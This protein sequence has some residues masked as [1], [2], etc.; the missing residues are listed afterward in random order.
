[1]KE[2]H[3]YPSPHF[4]WP[5]R[6]PLSTPLQNSPTYEQPLVRYRLCLRN[7]VDSYRAATTGRAVFGRFA[8]PCSETYSQPDHA[9]DG[10]LNP[11][12]DIHATALLANRH[13]TVTALCKSSIATRCLSAK[14]VVAKDVDVSSIQVGR[15]VGRQV[16][17]GEAAHE[18]AGGKDFDLHLEPDG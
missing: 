15:H 11:S 17:P 13:A 18:S 12:L 6:Q 2:R 8:E 4:S 1:M 5:S 14:D 7:H 9:S 16:R 10:L 3:T